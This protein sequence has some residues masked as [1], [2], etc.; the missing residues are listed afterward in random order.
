[1]TNPSR[2]TDPETDPLTDPLEAYAH[3]EAEASSSADF[4]RA[5]F[6]TLANQRMFVTLALA[7]VAV[8]YLTVPGARALL[9]GATLILSVI[10]IVLVVKHARVR[11]QEIWYRELALV[12]GGKHQG[13]CVG[14]QL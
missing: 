3:R 14:L 10:F 8:G 1:M 2:L 5:R 7:A 6:D 9:I 12:G 4:W 13:K 11:R